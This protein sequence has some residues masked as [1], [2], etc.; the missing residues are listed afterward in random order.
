MTPILDYAQANADFLFLMLLYVGVILLGLGV[1]RLG[2]ICTEADLLILDYLEKEISS[3][4]ELIST[5]NNVFVD[6]SK[7][8]EGRISSLRDRLTHK[9][10]LIGE[11]RKLWEITN[12]QTYRIDGD[13]D[14]IKDQL[15]TQQK[16]IDGNKSYSDSFLTCHEI[17]FE[18]IENQ[19]LT[20]K[21]Q[22]DTQTKIINDQQSLY[23]TKSAYEGL[24][25]MVKAQSE[26]LA[27]F[28]Q[29][30]FADNQP[31]GTTITWSAI[32]HG[33]KKP[34]PQRKARGRRK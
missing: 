27:R 14:K 18:N 33:G 24:L 12:E 20:A 22:L 1:K 19:V 7:E 6:W 26:K 17:L 30:H 16:L 15:A 5:R 8:L 13:V 25:G 23:I 10:N 2:R 34:K 4:R 3:L 9:D 11:L 29:D 21:G 31:G 32:G 28:E